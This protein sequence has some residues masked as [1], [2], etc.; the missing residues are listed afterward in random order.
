MGRI[1]KISAIGKLRHTKAP[2]RIAG[3]LV[4]SDGINLASRLFPILKL[5]PGWQ[6]GNQHILG[7]AFSAHHNRVGGVALDL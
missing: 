7:D 2:A 3:A 6:T 1:L 5:A 4:I